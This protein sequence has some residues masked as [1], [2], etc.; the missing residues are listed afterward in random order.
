MKVLTISIVLFLLCGCDITTTVKKDKDDIYKI[1][2]NRGSKVC[3][4][5]G[6]GVKITVDDM[7][8]KSGFLLF[9]AAALSKTPDIS[10]EQD[11]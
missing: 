11:D 3:F 5:D 2:Q 9:P 8:H 6:H 4:E 7:G 1:T 10:I